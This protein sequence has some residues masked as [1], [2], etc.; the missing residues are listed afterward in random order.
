MGT[1]KRKARDNQESGEEDPERRPGGQR[2]L[3]RGNSRQTPEPG[4]DLQADE[5]A[6]G[7][8]LAAGGRR[9]QPRTDA[10]ALVP[11]RHG[12]GDRSRLAR[13]HDGR[14]LAPRSALSGLRCPAPPA[15][16]P[17][18]FLGGVGTG[19]LVVAA[20]LADEVLALFAGLL[21]A[22]F[23]I[24]RMDA[25]RGLRRRRRRVDGGQQ[26]LGL[27]L[28]H[29]RGHD[30]ALEPRLRRRDRPQPAAQSHDRRRPRVPARGRR[31]TSIATDRAP[32]SSP[33]RAQWSTLFDAHGWEWGG[34]W[35]PGKDYHHFAKPGARPR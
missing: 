20:A 1:P 8:A 17:L 11:V 25:D 4:D 10:L 22:Q 24:A 34:D 21:A 35:S 32:A 6:R 12:C 14:L 3:A 19:Q 5:V 15:P 13:A 18:G 26:H 9:C 29:D 28:P 2:Q 27:Q 30:G 7:Q 23:P 33:A 31:P 16:C